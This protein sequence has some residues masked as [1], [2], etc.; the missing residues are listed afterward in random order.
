MGCHFHPRCEQ[1]NDLFLLVFAVFSD[2]ST[3]YHAFKITSVDC[4]I[5]IICSALLLLFKGKF[6]LRYLLVFCLKLKVKLPDFLL[7]FLDKSVLL[8]VLLFKLSIGA[9]TTVFLYQD[10]VL[11]NVIE[12]ALH[13][14]LC[15]VQD[16][17][18][19][20]YQTHLVLEFLYEE[21]VVLHC[22]LKL[23]HLVDLL[24]DL[25]PEN[26]SLFD[27]VVRPFLSDSD[28]FVEIRDLLLG[29][30]EVVSLLVKE[31]L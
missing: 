28:S 23:L 11:I 31:V 14:L 18:L 1:L 26:I 9:L 30:L 19:V 22:V 6:E 12:L 13:E 25:V 21:L 27:R 15:L 10:V 2:V 7:N 16:L 3:V 17:V 5:K 20:L 4:A 8:L 29:V 24:S